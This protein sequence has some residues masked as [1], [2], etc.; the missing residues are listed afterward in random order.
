MLG[1]DGAHLT[2]NGSPSTSSEEQGGANERSAASSGVSPIRACELTCREQRGIRPAEIDRN[3][4]LG[5]GRLLVDLGPDALNR[6]TL[7]RV[8]LLVACSD[9]IEEKRRRR[10]LRIG[11]CLVG[12]LFQTGQNLVYILP[13]HYVHH[14]A[15]NHPP[16]WFVAY[17][18]RL[19]T[20]VIQQ[21]VGS[22]IRGIFG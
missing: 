17:H 21:F 11:Q 22:L 3:K 6:W 5:Q 12:L 1:A 8:V 15:F 16:H 18:R 14:G 2:G 13:F 7:F 10:F 20:T 9:S 19:G 4:G